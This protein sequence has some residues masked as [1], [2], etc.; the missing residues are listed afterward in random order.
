MRLQRMVLLILGVSL[1]CLEM[2]QAISQDEP[3]TTYAKLTGTVTD[4]QDAPIANI[5]VDISVA[6]P[7]VGQGLFCPSCYLDCAKWTT[8]NEQGQFEIADLDPSLKFRLVA[9][10]PSHKAVQTDLINPAMGPVKIALSN[11]PTDVDPNQIV[12]GV[13]EGNLGIPIEGALVEPYGAKTS[14]RRWFGRVDV[15]STVTDHQGHFSMVLPKGFL[16]VDIEVFADGYCAVQTDLLTPGGD[17]KEI[18]VDDGATV[19]GKLVHMGQP[20][21]NMSIAVV[22][23]E[24][25]VQNGI[26]IKAVSSVTREDGAFEFKHLPPSQKYAIFSVVGDARRT[27]AKHILTTKTFAVPQS[28]QTRDLGKLSVS[29][30]VSIRGKVVHAD[31]E[32]LSSNTK[33]VFGREPAWDLISAP[34][35]EDGTFVIHGLPP[36]SYAIQVSGRGLQLEADKIPYQLLSPQSFGVLVT[37]SIEDLVITVKGN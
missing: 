2:P 32:P 6:A 35:H 27:K 25:G 8:T 1:S 21:A 23:V 10:G 22:Q 15:D 4:D 13:V 34:I 16:G 11:R 20:V 29:D 37:S 12:S 9:A 19:T 31:G 5:R 26:F 14:G 36:E 30:P 7:K 28:G 24:R 33:L 17:I 18:Q 3:A